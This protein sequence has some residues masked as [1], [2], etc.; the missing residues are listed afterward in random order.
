MADYVL[1]A[2]R[3]EGKGKNKV[4]KVR[5]AGL[6]PGVVYYK[7]ADNINVQIPVLDFNKTYEQVGT[8]NLLDLV[9]EDESKITVLVKEVQKH[10]V[11]NEYLHV[12]FVEVKMDEKIKLMVP[13][14]LLNRDEI[15]LQ[16][17]ILTQILD[18]VEVECY[19]SYIPSA[20]EVNV[21]N[22]Q[23]GDVL[24]VADLDIS[25]MEKID[26]L[27]DAEEAVCNLAEPE[28]FVE[29]ELTEEE[30]VDAADVPEIGEEEAEEA[31]VE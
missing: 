16:P 6:V 30:D 21:E 13:I 19:P 20:A 27:T 8:S 12:D 15:I 9:F 29:E 22:M 26:V 18:E 11:R 5:D 23:Y 3:R 31:E 17:S 4:D 1:H 10:P 25:S 28:E 24:T 2:Q 7:G 14:V